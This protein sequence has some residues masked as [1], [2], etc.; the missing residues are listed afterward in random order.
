MKRVRNVVLRCSLVI[1][2]TLTGIFGIA[3]PVAKAE[4]NNVV[5]TFFRTNYVYLVPG[6]SFT[7]SEVTANGFKSIGTSVFNSSD[8]TGQAVTGLDLE[9]DSSLAFDIVTPT[10]AQPGPPVYQWAFGDVLEGSSFGVNCALV[11]SKY[12]TTTFTPGFDVSRSLDK[13]V[14][15]TEDTQY[16]TITVTPRQP[17]VTALQVSVSAYLIGSKVNAVITS[18]TTDLAQGIYL[19][20][21]G[22]SLSIS[23]TGLTL[24]E[25][26]TINVTLQITPLVA[27][28]EYVPSI[29]VYRPTETLAT[30]TT[31]G[32]SVSYTVP[33]NCT[34][35]WSAQDSYTWQWS[36]L[37]TKIVCFHGYSN[38]IL[39][40]VNQVQA[41]Y[42]YMLTY[43]SQA[44]TFTNHEVVGNRSL[45]SSFI[46]T[47]DSTGQPVTGLNLKFDSNFVLESFTP[48]P[49]QLGPPTYIWSLG[50]LSENLLAPVSFQKSGDD[51]YAYTPG[52]DVSRSFDKTVFVSEDTQ[53]V[54]ITVIPR[55]ENMTSCNVIVYATNDDNVETIIISPT[56]DPAAGIFR[57]PEGQFIGIFLSGLEQDVEKPVEVTLSVTPKVPNAEYKP[58]VGIRRNE[59]INNGSSTGSSISHDLA[60]V[61]T[62][63]WSAVGEYA[64]NWT[65]FLI[66]SIFFPLYSAN[67]P[68]GTNI[69]VEDDD[70]NICFSEITT[71]GETSITTSTEPPEPTEGFEFE[72]TYYDV[73][74]T[75][76]YSDNITVTITYDDTGM[77]LE[78]E[79]LLRLYHWNGFVWEDV[80]VLPVDTDNN[81]ITGIA[82]SLSWFSV[83]I[84][85]E[86]TWLPPL[87]TSEIYLAQDGS[88]IPVKFQLTDANG[89]LVTDA[90]VIVTIT[91]DSSQQEVLS[92]IAVYEPDMQGYR[93]NAQT[94]DWELG[95]YTIHLSV[96]QEAIY[97]LNLVEKGQAKGKEK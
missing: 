22:S 16:L 66:R 46:N 6:D 81:E 12:P 50:D 93:I 80:T 97:G 25:P 64:W 71:G 57:D 44:D 7:N 47:N 70:I 31:A 53:T 21:D 60:D 95:E 3:S 1:V 91:R 20:P 11:P 34:W 94:K 82:T 40:P 59:I 43:Y 76:T 30:G 41:N 90:G 72:G 49:D 14:F 89:D 86:V 32:S 39:P 18:P 27:E 37:L 96:N 29:N 48:T 35:T 65:E 58:E 28:A 38:E 8:S 24:D 74:T 84:P 4:S 83:G 62:W 69:E 78:E 73:N 79:E 19:S 45:N 67:T 77:T 23:L 17:E 88:T 52:F 92:G 10:P 87:S 26:R 2:F 68:V 51:T 42:I 61:G 55:E 54:T 75:A 15:T 85:P 63:T 33:D 5:S 9:L 13:T 36:E 56:H